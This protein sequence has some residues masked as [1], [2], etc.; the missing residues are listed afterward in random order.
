MALPRRKLLL[1]I[2]LCPWF[3]FTL[4]ESPFRTVGA[5]PEPR[6][7][8]DMERTRPARQ[9]HR[10]TSGGKAGTQ[11]TRLVAARLL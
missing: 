9:S 2:G 5:E 6:A 7:E 11:G 1:S 4:V 3:G 10:L 8:P